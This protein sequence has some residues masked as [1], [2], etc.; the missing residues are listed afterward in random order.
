MLERYKEIFE[1][2]ELLE[3]GELVAVHR[4]SGNAERVKEYTCH[5]H[6]DVWRHEIALV[7]KDEDDD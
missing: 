5:Y 6:Y 2:I 1:E 7:N 4:E 3:N